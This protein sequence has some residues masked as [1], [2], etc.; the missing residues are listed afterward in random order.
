MVEWEQCERPIIERLTSV[1]WQ[2]KKGNEVLEGE[3]EPLLTSR[4]IEAIK[5]IN[6]VSDKEAQMALTILTTTPTSI[7]WL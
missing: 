3:N 1:G 6:N 4:L 5:R 2:Y 7:E